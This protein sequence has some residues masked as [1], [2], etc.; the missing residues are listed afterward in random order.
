[1]INTSAAN[2]RILAGVLLPKGVDPTTI[3]PAPAAAPT[4]PADGGPMPAGIPSTGAPAAGGFLWWPLL[5]L[6]LLCVLGG[7]R[8]VMVSSARR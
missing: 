7:L 8:L 5:L 1:M 2:A 3:V 6:A 4:A